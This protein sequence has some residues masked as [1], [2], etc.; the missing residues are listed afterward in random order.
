[1]VFQGAR[2]VLISS[3]KDDNKKK[4]QSML[5]NREGLKSVGG[6]RGKGV[7]AKDR[8]TKNANHSMQI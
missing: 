8:N 5:V 2:N 6:G 3:R 4:S 1:M 7:C